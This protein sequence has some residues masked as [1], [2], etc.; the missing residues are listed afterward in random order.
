[1][2]DAVAAFEDVSDASEK[3][4]RMPRRVVLVSDLQQ[5]AGSTPWASSERP[6]DV[7]LE[8]RTVESQGANAGL[9]WLVD[10]NE[11]DPAGAEKEPRVRVSNESGSSVE[12]FALK[13]LDAKGNPAGSAVP[14]YVPPGESR[15]VRVPRPAGPTPPTVLRLEGDAHAFDNTLYVAS[16]A[17][18][19]LNVLFVGDDAPESPTGLLY[20]LQRVFPETPDRTVTV[21]P[22]PTG[23][24]LAIESPRATPLV[25]V[26][27]ET[28]AP[29]VD[30][31]K[32]Y[33]NAGG[34]VLLVLTLRAARPRSARSPGWSPSRPTPRPRGAT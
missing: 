30:R 29:N 31:L 15:V 4:G 3:A 7:E 33:A 5:G 9:Q 25:V 17:R 14:V 32:A 23:N 27:G 26:S 8:L 24:A 16:T 19:E 28:S 22:R 21:T 34:T 18:E 12:S 10:P 2:V 20:Y 11:P 13:W 6:S 1:M